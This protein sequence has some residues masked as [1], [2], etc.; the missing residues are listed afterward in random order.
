MFGTKIV[1]SIVQR[2][3]NLERGFAL[4]PRESRWVILN[5]TCAVVAQ[6]RLPAKWGSEYGQ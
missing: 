5:A 4:V 3:R 6:A 2:F 1:S